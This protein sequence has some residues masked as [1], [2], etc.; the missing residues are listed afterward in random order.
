MSQTVGELQ[1][2]LDVKKDSLNA[3][4]QNVEKSTKSEAKAAGT[5]IGGFLGS[6]MTVAAGNLIASGIST[7]VSGATELVSGIIDKGFDR[8]NAIENAKS[9]LTAL[10]HSTE[11]TAQIMDSALASVKGT[12]YSLGDAASVAASAVAAGIKPGE[13]L[14]KTLTTIGDVAAVAKVDFNEMGSIFNKVAANGKVTTQE[15]NQLSDRGIPALDLLSKHLG[16]TREETQKLV[17]KGQVGFKDFE[18]AMV[19]GMGGAALALGDTWEGATSNVK[20]AMG[21]LGLEM[22]EPLKKALVPV[23]KVVMSSM[24]KLQPVMRSISEKIAP[25][26]GGFL[27]KIIPKLANIA[28]RLL[29][30][31]ADVGIAVLDAFLIMFDALEPVLD[32]IVDGIVNFFTFLAEHQEVVQA[33]VIAMTALSSILVVVSNAVPF[34]I[35][36]LFIL[37]THIEEIGQIAQMVGGAIKDFFVGVWGKIKN[38]A[39]AVFDFIGGIIKAVID[40]AWDIIKGFLDFIGGIA[41][42]VWDNLLQPIV[43]LITSF[44]ILQVAILARIVQFIYEKVIL[45]IWNF[46]YGIAHAITEFIW[47]VVEQIIGFITYLWN[48]FVN[49]ASGVAQWVYD[50]IISPIVGFFSDLFQK[51]SETVT[52]IVDNIKSIFGTV[53][54]WVNQH[55]IEPVKNFFGSMG[56]AISNTFNG[57]KDTVKNTVGTIAGFVKAPINGIIKA[58]NS[59]IDK[60]NGMTVPD[61]VPGIGGASPNFPKLPMLAEGGYATGATAAI[62]GEAGREAVLPLDRNTDNWS[63]LLASALADEFESRGGAGGGGVTIGEQKFIINNDMD[64]EDIGR[65]VMQSLRRYAQ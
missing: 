47:G 61:W 53:A 15:I 39:K 40:F 56:K 6:A 43:N 23:L 8:S 5:G 1:I 45:P 52:G 60:I 65:K 10:G 2:E 48:G 13:E 20:A 33:I 14:T 54:N 37:F 62:I 3:S 30:A 57:V 16:K 21:K 18:E 63:G 36:G 46:V 27:E 51:I 12:A 55:V 49:I 31:L 32:F 28:E 26:I 17:T 29:P 9:T 22:I 58:V 24:E 11:S 38:A 19:K 50:N 7:V 42:W 4:L 59:V 41:S 35:A 34:I 64:A 44:F 25:K